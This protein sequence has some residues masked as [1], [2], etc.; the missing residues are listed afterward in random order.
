MLNAKFKP[1]DIWPGKR[2]PS[3]SDSQFRA[4]YE[5]TLN[6]LENELAKLHADTTI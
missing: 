1:L 6:L 2:T 4:S 3:R 5:D